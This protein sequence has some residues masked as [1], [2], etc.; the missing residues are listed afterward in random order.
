MRAARIRSRR[1][2]SAAVARRRDEHGR[3]VLDQARPKSLAEARD[4]P[5]LVGLGQ[6]PRGE[7]QQRRH[8]RDPRRDRQPAGGPVVH[9]PGRVLASR[10]PAGAH[11]RAAEHERVDGQRAGAEEAGRRQPAVADDLELRPATGRVVEV[12]GQQERVRLARSWLGVEGVEQRLEVD[13]GQRG[14]LGILERAEVHDHAHVRRRLRAAGRRGCR[15]PRP[16]PPAGAVG[17]GHL[18]R[19]T[20]PRPRSSS[21]RRLTTT[22]SASTTIRRL[23]FDWPTRRSRKVIGTSTTRA[24]SRDAR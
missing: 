23:I 9:G 3:G 14:A 7:V 1:R 24:P 10:A 5:G 21:Q 18:A 13:R 2:A 12:G 20:G 16:R 19:G 11:R 4:G 8:H 6:R 17:R 15:L 22:T